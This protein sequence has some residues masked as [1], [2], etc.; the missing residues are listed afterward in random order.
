MSDTEL[1]AD[2]VGK[3]KLKSM[4]MPHKWLSNLI[5]NK[6]SKAQKK[7]RGTL[8]WN[9]TYFKAEYLWMKSH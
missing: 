3:A 6:N 1:I 5:K 2:G 8:I 9:T 4:E 7:K